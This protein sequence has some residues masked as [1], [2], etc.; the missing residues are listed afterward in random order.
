MVG[1]QHDWRTAVVTGRYDAGKQIV[2]RYRNVNDRPGFEIVTP[3]ILPDGT[4]VLVD[5]GLPAPAGCR[6]GPEQHPRRTGR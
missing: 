4:A 6:A 5:R 2:L 1:E 3:L